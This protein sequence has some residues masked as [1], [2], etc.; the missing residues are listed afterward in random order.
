[1]KGLWRDLFIKVAYR[2][3]THV[4]LFDLIR[5]VYVPPK[6]VYRKVIIKG[7]FPVR[8][9]SHATFRIFNHGRAEDS[10]IETDLFWAGL[11]NGWE[12]TSLLLWALLAKDAQCIHDIGANTGVYALTSKCIN[13]K[14]AVVA[15]EPS[16]WVYERLV[17]NVKLN[18][19]EFDI[20]T[21]MLAVSDRS[22]EA[23][24]YDSGAIDSA[25][26]QPR[27]GVGVWSFPVSTIRLD[28]YCAGNCVP[29][30]LKIDVEGHE[31]HVLYG[32]GEL[33]AYVKPT[34]LIEILDEP[35][36]HGVMRAIE[37][38]DY[39]I[40]AIREG[41]GIERVSQPKRVARSD[42]NYLLCQAALSRRHGLNEH[43]SHGQIMAALDR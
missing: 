20:T 9:T 10:A 29:D 13:P 28:E 5:H 31:Q 35:T 17:K 34:M 27:S 11:G 6:N 32:L 33:L 38:L 12:G 21:E 40:F 19:P 26:V 24:L 15:F 7:A 16:E 41:I 18:G 2:I 25:S 14:A 8:V 37:G 42:R 30:L 39:R 3:R 43:T 1:M 4:W 22:G 23:I 36:A